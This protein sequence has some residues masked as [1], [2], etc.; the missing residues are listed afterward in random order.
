MITPAS[1][2]KYAQATSGGEDEGDDG[3]EGMDVETG[4][5]GHGGGSGG[6]GVT[7]VGGHGGGSGG[8]NIPDLGESTDFETGERDEKLQNEYQEY[9]LIQGQSILGPDGEYLGESVPPPDLGEATD[10]ETGEREALEKKF[11][12]LWGSQN[13]ASQIQGDENPPAT[14]ANQDD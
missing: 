14:S 10:F 4:V 6:D 5:G 8:G 11:E 12:N 7:G 3:H 1:V 2:L 9:R 13:T